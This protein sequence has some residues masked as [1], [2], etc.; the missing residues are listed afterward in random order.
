RRRRTIRPEPACGLE[1]GC[2]LPGRGWSSARIRKLRACLWRRLA[3]FRLRPP[4]TSVYSQR[5]IRMSKHLAR[6]DRLRPSRRAFTAGAIA[7]LAVP[8]LPVRRARA[9]AAPL[10]IGVI[11]PRTG[12]FA[13]PG[14]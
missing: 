4:K 6:L 14:Q 10:K 8:A 11:L 3:L 5:R 13:Q 7:A 9:Q 2:P 12:F 1:A